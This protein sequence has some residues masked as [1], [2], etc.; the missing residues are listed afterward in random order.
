MKSLPVVQTIFYA[1]GSILSLCSIYAIFEARKQYKKGLRQRTAENLVALE[2][3]F[4]KLEDILV[5][6]DPAGGRYEQELKPTVE[7]SLKKLPQSQRSDADRVLIRQLDRFLRFMLLLTA[8]VR[9][10]LLIRDALNYEYWYWFDAIRKN[11]DLK[12]YT[13]D[14]FPTLAAALKDETL[15]PPPRWN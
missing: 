14:Y 1:I 11:P 13:Q 8:L 6:I 3:Q 4:T 5:L 2:K 7:K 9:F 10:E 15:T 12:D